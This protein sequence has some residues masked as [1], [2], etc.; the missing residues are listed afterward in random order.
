[1]SGALVVWAMASGKPDVSKT[2]RLNVALIFLGRTKRI[3]NLL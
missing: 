1:M 3:D 2:T